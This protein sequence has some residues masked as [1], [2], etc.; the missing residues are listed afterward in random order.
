MKILLEVAREL[1]G[2]FVA[3]LRLTL[4]ILA[5]IALVA[6]LNLWL[7]PDPAVC[8][9]VLLGGCVLIL[10]EAILRAARGRK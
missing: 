3:D 9:L 10:I 8:G 7:R 4:L 2:M 5:L 1:F 6:A